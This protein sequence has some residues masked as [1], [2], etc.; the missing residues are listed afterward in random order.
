VDTSTLKIFSSFC[1]LK[2]KTF[3]G[4]P[5]FDR[6]GG[7]TVRVQ[8]SLIQKMMLAAGAMAEMRRGR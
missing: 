8:A 5:C 6:I 2:P 3:W 4:G 7:A 1:R